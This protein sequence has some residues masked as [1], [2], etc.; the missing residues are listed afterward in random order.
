MAYIN[1]TLK[2]VLT[3]VSRSH[4][5]YYICSPIKGISLKKFVKYELKEKK[6]ME[7]INFK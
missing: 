3:A 4:L 1:C 2:T 7:S 5:M 6:V